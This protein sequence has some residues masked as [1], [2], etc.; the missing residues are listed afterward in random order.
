MLHHL[1]RTSSGDK[2]AYYQNLSRCRQN[3][4]VE[5]EKEYVLNEGRGFLF[6][7]RPEGSK[8]FYFRYTFK[9]KEKKI[10]LGEYP[11]LSLS[12]ARSKYAEATLLLKAGID[13]AAPLF[14]PIIE[15]VIEEE[16]VT[17]EWIS[18]GY[19]VWSEENHSPD[20]HKIVKSTI[21]KHIL[22]GIGECKI[23]SIS[24]RDAIDLMENIKKCGDGAARNA[25]K[26]VRGM[27]DY[28]VQREYIDA[29]PFLKL[30]KA[31]PALEQVQRQRILSDSELQH[32]WKKV[33][34]GAGSPEVKRAILLT[35]FTA[36]RPGECAGVHSREI[37]G[38]WWTIPAERAQKG[39]R[40]HRVY[41]TATAK[42]LLGNQVGYAYPSPKEGPI[43]ERSLPQLITK[44]MKF[45]G[46]DKWTP[47]DLRRTA[48]TLMA[49]LGIREEDAEAVLNHAK[50]GM[51][52]VYN[53]HQYD[54]EKKAA[55]IKL[56][57]ELIRI[58][59]KPNYQLLTQFCTSL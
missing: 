10:C 58:I 54:N 51:V 56:E 2:R 33:I 19:F 55:L 17:V 21:I 32:V 29:S 38:D 50:K 36:Q 6:R 12:D 16:N 57:K 52:K 26:I 11:S 49:R 30:A 5:P 20:W 14:I 15:E 4:I 46:L 3:V 27:F 31:I 22:P 59:G 48:R 34:D 41:L 42:M 37:D 1:Q 23:K 35:L 28:A 8:A 43:T 47:H 18:K 25:L 45:Y 9:G 44:K 40:D 24:K 13:P 53:L 7:V 39:D